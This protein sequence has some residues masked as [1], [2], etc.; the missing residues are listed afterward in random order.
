MDDAIAREEDNGGGWRIGGD[1]E[2]S[3]GHSKRTTD[4]TREFTFDAEPHRRRATGGGD[5]AYGEVSVDITALVLGAEAGAGERECHADHHR[6]SDAFHCSGAPG[7][8]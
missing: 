2:G 8:S 7:G 4:T 6:W 3:A 1:D 5:C